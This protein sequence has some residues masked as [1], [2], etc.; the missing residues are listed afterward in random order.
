MRYEML[1]RGS[2][3]MDIVMMTER[4]SSIEPRIVELNPRTVQV[5]DKVYEEASMASLATIRRR[6]DVKPK[7]VRRWH[8][9]QMS[10]A[11]RVGYNLARLI[12]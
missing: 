4:Y 12:L 6:V 2:D 5:G 3:D 1:C 7:F 10:G 11:F 8:F 9:M